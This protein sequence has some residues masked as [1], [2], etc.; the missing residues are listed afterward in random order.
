[1]KRTILTL[2]AATTLTAAIPAIAS[3]QS[4]WLSINQR[5]ANLDARIDAGVRSGQLTGPE[6]ANLRTEFRNIA[7]L[8]ANYRRSAP[9]LT[10]PER[11]DLDR[12]FDV[13]SGR[14]TIA[15]N[16]LD[17]RGNPGVWQNINDRQKRLD[18]RIDRAQ[19]NGRL[20]WREARSLRAEF[21][22]IAQLEA[23]YRKSRPGLT[24]AE[25]ADLD[26]RFDHLQDRIHDE[27]RDRQYGYGYGYGR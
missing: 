5:Q 20:D 19:R 2:L 9:G 6:A 22:A 26:R 15:S 23:N 12:R 18:E 13:L 11:A 3:A 1:M 10:A 16:D 17:R 21:R 14:I 7:G 4:Q 27:S 25:R 8:E 24:V